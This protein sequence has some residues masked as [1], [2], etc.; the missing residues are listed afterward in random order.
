MPEID[1]V[2]LEV[3]ADIDAYRRKLRGMSTLVEKE[4]GIQEARARKL[5]Q[6]MKRAT[7]SIGSTLRGL[8][9]TIAAAFSAREVVGLLDSFTRYENALKVAGLQGKNLA[10]VQEQL[11]LVAQKN[12]VALEA[13]GTLYG[14]AA[15]SADTLGASQADLLRFTEAVSASLRITGTTTQEASGAL[16]QLGQ[17]LGSP[18]VQA[19]EFN[20]LIDTMRPLL[21]E[22]AKEIE[23]TGGT[24]D[25]LIRK[26]KDTSGPGVSNV[27]LFN[28]ITAAMQRLQEQ[29]DKTSLTVSAG[30][31]NVTSALTKY[32]GE[33]DKANGVSAA[34]GSALDALARNLDILIPSLA[35]VATTIGTKMV[36]SAIAGSAAYTTLSGVLVGTTSA[37]QGLTVASNALAKSLPFLAI[38]AVVTA[39]GYM[40]VESGRASAEMA[41][42]DAEIAS[43]KNEADAMEARLQAAG[44][45]TDNL[46]SAAQTARGDMI[47]LAGGME[48]ARQKAAELGNQAVTTAKQLAQMRLQQVLGQRQ[49]ITDARNRRARTIRSQTRTG[50]ALATSGDRTF[51]AVEDTQLQRLATLE[52]DLR[53]QINYLEAGGSA[54]L[55]STGTA[56]RPVTAPSAGRAAGSRGAGSRSDPVAQARREAQAR[57][58]Y[59]S[60]L[61]QLQADEL[62]ARAELTGSIEDRLA[63]DLARL[64]ADT[65]SF[66]RQV[67]LD[68]ELDAAQ[69]EKLIAERAEVDVLRRKALVREAEVARIERQ[70]AIAADIARADETV[71]QSQLQL[72]TN[73]EDRARL[74]QALLDLQY[75]QEQAELDTLLKT[76]ELNGAKQDEIDAVRRRIEASEQVYQ[77]ETRGVA[78]DNESPLQRYARDLGEQD[79]GDQAEQLIVDEIEHVRRGMRDAISD[80]IGTDD[81]LIT[82]LIDLL[83]QDLIF[84]PLADALANQG[85]GGLIGTL[86]QVGTAIFG[87]A[88]AAGG[89]VS[90]GKAYLVGERG[91][92]LMVPNVPGNIIPNSRLSLGGGGS[93]VA[94]VRLELAG[95]I[96]ARIQRVSG[97]VAVEVVRA[98]APGIV[99][100]SANE[101]IRRVNRPTI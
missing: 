59:A 39:L 67:S 72:A 33:A 60:E 27:E 96:D 2:V 82:G 64:Q 8:A 65:R 47:D 97:P 40:A 44:I 6:E 101:T 83:L 86:A 88:R 11:F 91:P 25:G 57:A 42:L 41:A 17:A 92:E 32:F 70:A 73:R 95:D 89:P 85:G 12:G 13:V 36:G 81:P 63:A 18:R 100:A 53:R 19:E 1:A 68:E 31:T 26:L 20:S 34:L 90:A 54:A 74:E 48:G 14:R 37:T 43:T 87:G 58:A 69:R 7:G 56:P 75:Q 78:R 4:F 76:L 62:A 50:D 84:K 16:L 93:G 45:Q 10:E 35:I 22:A 24:L 99:D 38:S 3:R 79:L 5:E 9:G 61:E 15:Q 55:P 28:G 30:F 94:T 29:A 21:K 66:A 98:S 52:A 77:N 80:A 23:G 49:D 71:L 51:R 46:G